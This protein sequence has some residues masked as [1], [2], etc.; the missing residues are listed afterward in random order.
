MGGIEDAKYL[1]LLEAMEDLKKSKIREKDDIRCYHLPS[2][3]NARF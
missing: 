2:E 1:E 3:L